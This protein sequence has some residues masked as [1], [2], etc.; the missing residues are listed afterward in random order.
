MDH[1]L[2]FLRTKATR[3]WSSMEIIA[4]FKE[5][6]GDSYD[7]ALANTLM[8]V[9]KQTPRIRQTESDKIYAEMWD[10]I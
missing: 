6:Y 4:I 2:R 10:N 7:V 9:L 1:F 5:R 8:E 3:S